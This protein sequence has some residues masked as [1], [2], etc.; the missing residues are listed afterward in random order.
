MCKNDLGFPPGELGFPFRGIGIENWEYGIEIF[1]E[2][3]WDI[4]IFLGNIK[5]SFSLLRLIMLAKLNLVK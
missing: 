1:G 3:K 4:P 2:K 5:P